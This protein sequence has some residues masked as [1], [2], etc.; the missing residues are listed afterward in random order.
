[1]ALRGNGER[2]GTLARTFHWLVVVLFILLAASGNIIVGMEYDDPVRAMRVRI[3]R[4]VGLAMFTVMAA[5]LCWALVDSRPQP[6]A[7]LK[8]WERL[9][10][11]A[12]HRAFYALL[13]AVPVFG[14]LF[15]GASVDEVQFAGFTLPSAAEFSRDASET[16]IGIHKWLT[17]LIAFCAVLHIV[18]VIKHHFMDGIPIWRRM[19]F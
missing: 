6:L 19:I 3:H 13:M 5:R 14:Y 18:G 7:S 1:M 15:S 16:L 9:L 10:S 17:R 12:V 4:T 11:I 8:T 2:Y